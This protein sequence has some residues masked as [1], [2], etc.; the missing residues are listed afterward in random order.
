M[1]VVKLLFTFIGVVALSG[2]SFFGTTEGYKQ[3]LN[4]WIGASEA[5]LIGTWGIPTNSYTSGNTK[6]LGYTDS[7][8]ISVP[9]TEPSYHT[10][11][12]TT[13]SGN[14]IVCNTRATG[15]SSG[16]SRTY[17]CETTFEIVNG[18]V[19]NY[20]FKGNN[21]LARPTSPT[22][23]ASAAVL[24]PAVTAHVD[25]P[26]DWC[27]KH[28]NSLECG[29]AEEISQIAESYTTSSPYEAPTDY[30]VH[31]YCD[32]LKKL[33]TVANCKKAIKSSTQENPELTQASSLSLK[34]SDQATEEEKPLAFTP[35][36]SSKD[37]EWVYTA[38]DDAEIEQFFG[39]SYTLIEKHLIHRR[40]AD[41]IVRKAD[42][43]SC[44][45][46]A[47]K[48]PDQS[49][50]MIEIREADGLSVTRSHGFNERNYQGTKVY[51]SGASK[52]LLAAID[53]QV[54][55]IKARRLDLQ[56]LLETPNSGEAVIWFGSDLKALERSL[57]EG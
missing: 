47:V 53:Q 6:Y 50:S 34:T 16:S 7:Q 29:G 51:V 13:V 43:S 20:S 55:R 22:K 25:K 40:I 21:C 27:E 54:R 38:T 23:T 19:K 4:T 24:A 33:T 17:F 30:E 14:Q 37:S 46:K 8:T 3:V 45:L 57:S 56:V 1:R 52:F 15:G 36:R 32:E 44:R 11:C 42:F 35:P 2:C 48:G 49:H 10:D 26:A 18:Y 28:P 31:K 9:G 41:C 12:G 39:L 5:S